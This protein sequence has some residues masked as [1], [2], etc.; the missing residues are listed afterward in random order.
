MCLSMLVKLI[1][2]S[3]FPCKLGLERIKIV[4]NSILELLVLTQLEVKSHHSLG[5]IAI[6]RVVFYDFF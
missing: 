4:N 6:I 2:L 1:F 3:E 5:T